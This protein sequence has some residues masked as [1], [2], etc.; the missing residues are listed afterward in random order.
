MAPS[1]LK[2]SDGARPQRLS[3]TWSRPATSLSCHSAFNRSAL[4]GRPERLWFQSAVARFCPSLPAVAVA[5]S[6]S[7]RKARLLTM[8]IA[9]VG[10]L[11][12]LSVP[13]GP[14][15]T[16]T[17]SV[18]NTSRETEPRSRTP[19]TKMLLEVSKPRM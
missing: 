1:R 13:A 2:P 6:A 19:S 17:C 9:P 7:P 4:P 16:S 14:L 11:R 3:T 10:A 15:V 8:L 18:L 12:P 5:D